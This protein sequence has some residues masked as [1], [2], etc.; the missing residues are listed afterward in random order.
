MWCLYSNFLRI[1][2]STNMY[3][4]WN[5]NAPSPYHLNKM[6]SFY[7]RAEI[8]YAPPTVDVQLL[9]TSTKD[10]GCLPRKNAQSP[11]TT[12]IR[13]RQNI[14]KADSPPF[15]Q[16]D[17]STCACMPPNGLVPLCPC[18]AAWLYDWGADSVNWMQREPS[19]KQEGM[20]LS[21]Q[22]GRAPEGT[23]E[24]EIQK[25]IIDCMKYGKSIP[26]VNGSFWSSSCV[27]GR[28]FCSDV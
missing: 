7:Y 6:L 18:G 2:L 12:L 3:A 26:N 5:V 1:A 23:R 16:A 28:R 20:I 17:N 25:L 19:I 10:K 13:P 21:G 4:Q 14:L 15:T 24:D 22:L 9:P 8:K 11:P 27:S